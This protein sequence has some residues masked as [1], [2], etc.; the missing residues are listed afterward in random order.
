[1]PWSVCRML[2]EARAEA[3]EAARRSASSGDTRYAT[4]EDY[5]NWI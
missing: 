1:M 2:F 5:D 4:A 3:Y